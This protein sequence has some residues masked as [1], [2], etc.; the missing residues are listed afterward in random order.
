ML[1]RPPRSTLFPYTTLFRSL[2]PLAGLGGVFVYTL[3]QATGND[4]FE[5]WL[6][7]SDRAIGTIGNANELA[8]YA[9]IAL[10]AI[11]P[12]ANRRDRRS[13]VTAGA[14]AAASSFII[15]EAES[16]SGIGAIVLFVLLLPAAW[17]VARAPWRELPRPAA[18]V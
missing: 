18:A 1:R 12:W 5:W 10:T 17:F 4:P 3:V 6:D 8:A 7:T 11:A 9:I 2:L 15:F 13:L 14:V 16:R